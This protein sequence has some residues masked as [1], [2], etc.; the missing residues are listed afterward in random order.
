MIKIICK[1]DNADIQTINVQL[2]INHLTNSE[3]IYFKD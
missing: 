3:K 2:L 1:I